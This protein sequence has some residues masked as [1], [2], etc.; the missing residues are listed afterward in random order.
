MELFLVQF[1]VFGVDWD[2]GLEI[3]LESLIPLMPG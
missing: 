2:D 3:K 1:G